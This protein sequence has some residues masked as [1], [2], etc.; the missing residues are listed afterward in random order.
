MCIRDSEEA[1]TV[2]VR[3]VTVAE[4]V[5]TLATLSRTVKVELKK[6]ASDIKKLQRNYEKE[7]GRGRRKDKSKRRGNTNSGIMKAHP[8]SDVL[9]KFM[10]HA[11]SLQD[12]PLD[13]RDEYSRVDV[14]KA[15]S[16][17]VK[18]MELQDKQPGQGKYINLDKHLKKVFPKLKKAKGED[19]LKYT[20]IMKHIGPHFPPTE[21]K[22]S[23]SA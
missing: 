16:S 14:L 17:Y 21:S 5:Q 19:R 1:D 4:Q 3:L 13:P 10:K 6:L 18:T 15:V 22:S 20:L 12:P 8:V 23:T 11:Y 7:K 9:S 2:S